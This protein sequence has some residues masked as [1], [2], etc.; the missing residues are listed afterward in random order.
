MLQ[1]IIF[2][3]MAS[4]FLNFNLNG[5]DCE[6]LFNDRL[7]YIEKFRI[8]EMPDENVFMYYW[9]EGYRDA[10]IDLLQDFENSKLLDNH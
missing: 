3:L 10:L 4:V 5:C 7:E 9:T 1:K 2:T 8:Y 6:K